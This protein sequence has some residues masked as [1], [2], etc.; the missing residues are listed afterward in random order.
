MAA[1]ADCLGCDRA[2]RSDDPANRGANGRLRIRAR[3]IGYG[4][5][6][7]VPALHGSDC[8]QAPRPP[9]GSACSSVATACYD[10]FARNPVNLV[11]FREQARWQKLAITW[12]LANF[13]PGVP[14]A[15]Q[16]D[17]VARA[18]DMWAACSG[19]TFQS[20]GGAADITIRFDQGDPYPFEGPGGSLGYAFFPGTMRAGEVH[21]CQQEHWSL[22]PGAALIDI[23]TVVLHEIGHALGLEHSLDSDDVMHPSYKTS[24]A[25]SLTGNDKDAIGRLYGEP[26]SGLPPIPEVNQDYCEPVG[27]LASFEDPDSDLD[28]IPDTVEVFALGTDPFNPDTDMDGAIDSIEVFVDRTNPL[29]PFSRGIPVTPPQARIIYVRAGAEGANNG[30]SWADAFTDLQVAL[31]AAA[32]STTVPTEVWVAAGRYIPTQRVEAAN[33]QSVVFAMASFVGLYG[34]FAGSE[35]DRRQRIP[36]VNVT[37]LDGNGQAREGNARP[38][39]SADLISGGTLDGFTI[40]GGQSAGQGG[41]VNFTIS[42]FDIAPSI[43]DCKFIGNVSNSFG[44]GLQCNR[45]TTIADCCFIGNS[46]NTGAGAHL[47]AASGFDT[48][49]YTVVNCTFIGNQGNGSISTGGGLDVSGNAVIVNGLFKS[50]TADFGAGLDFGGEGSAIN[51]TFSGNSTPLSG[52]IAGLRVSSASVTASNCIFWENMNADGMTERAQLSAPGALTVNNSC[53]MNIVDFVG[54]GNIGLNPQFVDPNGVDDIGGTADDN[55]RLQNT[56]PCIGSGR[57]SDVPPDGADIDNDGNFDET[58]PLDL[59]R[60]PRFNGTVDMGAYET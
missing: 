1:G 47:G 14:Q 9:V 8:S 28:G 5:V 57:N 3:T 52:G 18:F 19:L 55:L 29:D 53:V 54:N 50:N 13:A 17:A 33:E 40:T 12:R 44:G 58:T 43:R 4:L 46:G 23:F 56:S 36:E 27:L 2:L 60:R 6:L 39:V 24:G 35:L 38:V 15:D 16:V 51:C 22:A 25:T 48:D 41:G 7:I 11:C 34:G 49:T 26:G 20:V 32:A 10:E 37:I 45:A 21:L 31:A 59:D 30:S 42:N